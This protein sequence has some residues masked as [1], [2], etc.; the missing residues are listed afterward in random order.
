MYQNFARFCK[1]LKGYA[2]SARFLLAF[3]GFTRFFRFL[4]GFSGFCEVL[5]SSARFC[6]FSRG[7][8]G[9]LKVLHVLNIPREADEAKQLN[10]LM[11]QIVV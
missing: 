5:N 11:K 9:F 3:A 1:F 10:C 8:A 7:F 4:Q 6:R 2:C